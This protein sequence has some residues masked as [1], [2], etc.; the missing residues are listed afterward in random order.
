MQERVALTSRPNHPLPLDEEEDYDKITQQTR[1]LDENR[2][3]Y[4]NVTR[5]TPLNS[6][7]PLIKDLHTLNDEIAKRK[8]NENNLKKRNI[9]NAI[10]TWSKNFKTIWKPG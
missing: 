9:S 2:N 7:N 6:F 8:K 3:F 4:N 5:R 1:S 10:K